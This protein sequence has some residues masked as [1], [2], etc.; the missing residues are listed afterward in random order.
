MVNG[1]TNAITALKVFQKKMGNSANNVANIGTTGF[2]KS[3][4]SLQDVSPENISTPSGV[5][6]VGRGTNMHDVA[7]V[8]S[9]G[10]FEPTSSPTDMA[11]G[12]DGFFI[13]RAPEGGDYYTRDGHFNFDKEGRLMNASGHVAQ[14]WEVDPVS[15]D[16]RGS[17]K[18]IEISSL[19][20]PPKETTIAKNTVY[21]SA[22]GYGSVHLESAAISGNGVISGSYSNGQVLNLYQLALAKFNSPE[23]LEKMGGNVY[24]ET[25]DSGNAMTGRPGINGLGRIASNALE[26]SNVD[27]GEEF[28]DIIL[29][30]HGFQANLKVVSA[31]DEMVGSLLDII[32]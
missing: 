3:Q 16:I 13:V 6:Q 22:D 18:D 25:T 11:I 31:E 14:G 19:T 4:S 23:G 24:A 8:F 15:G 7:G 27:L 28:V 30:Q 29:T 32:S 5:L 20:S 26:Q 9:Q 17:I 21:S 10:S 2:K 12:G 1:I